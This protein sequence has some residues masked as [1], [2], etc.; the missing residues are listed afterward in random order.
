M[1]SICKKAGV[2]YFRFHPFRHFTASI[3]DDSGVPIGVIQR[4]LGHQNRK[5]TEGYLHSIGEAE[6]RAMDRLEKVDIFS[7]RIVRGKNSPTNMHKEFWQRKVKRPNYDVLKK[8]VRTLGYVGTG[9]KYGVTDNAVRKWIKFY[10]KSLT[11]DVK[12]ISV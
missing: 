4:I 12:C 1:G 7:T 2:K 9:N 8:D 10:E 3:L 11:H 5:T 6:R